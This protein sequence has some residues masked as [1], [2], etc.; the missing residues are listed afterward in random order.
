MVQDLDAGEL[1]LSRSRGNCDF[2]FFQDQKSRVQTGFAS[3]GV[4]WGGVLILTLPTYTA[5]AL[6]RRDHNHQQ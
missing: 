3:L 6:P 5:P 4:G 2:T 1:Q